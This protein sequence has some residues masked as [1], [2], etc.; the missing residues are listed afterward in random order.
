MGRNLLVLV[1]DE[2]SRDQLEAAV[3]GRG[4]GYPSVYVVVPAHVG[5]LEWLATDEV[6]AHG[7]ASARVLEAEWL[8]EGAGEI[9][10]ESGS[11]DPVQ[12]AEDA[13]AR[14]PADEIVV[15]GKRP[16]DEELLE[17]LR[18]L[19]PPVSPS[20]LAVRPSSLRTR[21]RDAIRSL[22]SGRSSSTP[23]VAFVGANLGLLLIGVAIALVATLIVWL[24]GSL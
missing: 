18:S 22:G 13:L 3:E 16:L 11:P 24:V 17:R 14:F 5:P 9:G 1:L 4:D 15:V 20:G 6:R 8:L 7:E 12:A 19:G 10:G 2:V 21:T 23:F